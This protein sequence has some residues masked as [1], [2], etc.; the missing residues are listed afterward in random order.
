M[1]SAR[2]SSIRDWRT[3]GG[4]RLPAFACGA[5][6]AF[7]WSA[8]P[9]LADFKLCNSTTSRIGVAIGYEQKSGWSTEGWWNI[10]AQSCETI[11]R[12][13]P[14]SRYLYVYAIDYDRG[15]DWS[16]SS[17]MCTHDKSFRIRDTKDCEKR[18]HRRTG[19]MEVDT[20]GDRDW[21]VRFNDPE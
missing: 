21:T 8:A 15:G 2:S 17:F 20:N 16:G 13:A 10:P 11:L 19:F 14:P 4:R 1:I 3:G 9:A 7:G 5:L 6:A 18:G 12:G